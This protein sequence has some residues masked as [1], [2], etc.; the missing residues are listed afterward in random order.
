MDKISEE[1]ITL[2]MYLVV[3]IVELSCLSL[4]EL[5]YA[6][7]RI[8]WLQNFLFLAVFLF[9]PVVA[10]MILYGFVIYNF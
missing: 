6:G 3:S 7:L 8:C 5:L 2:S 9:T 10:L 1:G 4:M